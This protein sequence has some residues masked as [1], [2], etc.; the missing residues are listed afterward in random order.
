MVR[1]VSSDVSIDFPIYHGARSIKKAILH[2][3]VGGLIG[4]NNRSQTCVHAI[5]NLSFELKEG[6]RVGL[7]GPNGAGKTTLLRALAGIY[8][9]ARGQILVEGKI[10]SLIDCFSGFDSESSGYDNLFLR[11][12]ILGYPRSAIEEKIDEIVEFSELGDFI[13]LPMRMYSSG[14]A[15]RLVFA[16]VTALDAEILLLDEWLNVGDANFVEKAQR[17]AMDMVDR[18]SI[19]VIA[20]HTNDIIRRLCN[21]VLWLEHGLLKGFGETNEV[22]DKY[23]SAAPA[24]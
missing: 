14:M 2:H 4:Y 23:L 5:A 17:R 16:A 21:K 6:D 12:S 8:E 3:T 9:P 10:T 18:A 22:L 24:D 1:I 11:T 15:A 19:M 13:H 20:T 7:I